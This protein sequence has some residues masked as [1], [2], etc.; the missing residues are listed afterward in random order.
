MNEEIS[1]DYHNR[2]RQTRLAIQKI[3]KQLTGISIMRVLFFLVFCWSGYLSIKLR[4]SYPTVIFAISS[5]CIFLLFVLLAAR[6]KERKNYLLTIEKINQNELDMEDGKS[7]FLA[8]GASFPVQNDFTVDL[9]IF[10]PHSLYHLLNRAGSEAG[11]EKLRIA[12]STPPITVS[13]IQ[14]KQQAVKALSSMVEFRQSL[15]ALTLQMNEKESLAGLS[16]EL[17]AT[18]FELA[19]NRFWKWAKIIWPIAGLFILGYGLWANSLRPI[20][21][22]GIFGLLLLSIVTKRINYLYNHVSKKSYLYTQYAKCFELILTTT[23]DDPFLQKQQAEMEEASIAFRQLARL[24]SF[25]DLRASIFSF[26]I[27]GLFV[28][29]LICALAYISWCKK[30]Q[31]AIGIWLDNLGEWELLNSIST[32][33]YN[34]PAYIFP[35]FVEGAA[36]IEAVGLGHPLMNPSKTVVNDISL[37][38]SSVMHLITGSNMSGKSTYLR[39]VGLNCILAQIGSP[40]Y[41]SK[42]IATPVQLLT[43]FHHIDSL[44]DSTSYFYAELRSLKQ[45]IDSID[46]TVPSL[47]LLDEVMRGTNSQDKH[48]GTAL[49][50]KKLLNMPC[51]TLLA[52]HDTALGILAETYQGKVENY[53]FESELNNDGLHFDFV[54]RKGVAQTTNATYLMQQMGII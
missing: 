52:T 17:S 31:S 27:N 44:T 45:I 42:Y 18:Y 7:S 20:L 40:V 6:K 15:L 39:T 14:Q 53:C 48:D 43:S 9:N 47:I 41:A 34:R 28:T 19:N 21:L 8:D 3:N 29:D 36:S 11:K 38:K 10:G 13:L 46:A 30:Y 33:H 51:I 22:F 2:I 54:R 50:I 5:F 16:A 1:T 49:L 23:F 24:V 35:E 32:L 26:I 4:F 25:F 12:L 37:G